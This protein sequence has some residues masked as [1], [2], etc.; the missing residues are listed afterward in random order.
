MPKTIQI[1]DIDDEVYAG[2]L[3]RRGAVRT[4]RLAWTVADVRGA[5][6][7]D[8]ADV[9]MARRLRLGLPLLVDAMAR[10]AS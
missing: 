9:E 8:L 4:H 1:R 5:A 7:P 6:R 2:R 3:S 10:R